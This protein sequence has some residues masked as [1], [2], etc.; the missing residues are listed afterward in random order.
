M[1][2][3]ALLWLSSLTLPAQFAWRDAGPGRL[4]LIEK[5]R[6]VMVFNY[7]PQLAPGVA[8]DRRRCCYIHPY[9][10]PSG[11]VLT[12]DFP[13]DHLHHRGIFWAWPQVILDG[14]TLDGWMMKGL[15]VRHERF[16]EKKPTLL[17]VENGWYAGEKK[18][19]TETVVITP[20]PNHS[21]ALAV[22]LE[23]LDKPVTLGGSREAGKGYGGVSVRFAPRENTVIRTSEGAIV[24]DEDLNP[25]LMAELEADYR[26][27]KSRLRI[28]A[29][30]PLPWCL[31]FYG[32]LGPSWPAQAKATLEP[33]K[34]VTLRYRFE[35]FD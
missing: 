5:G 25:H 31:R 32:F 27:N 16:L 20:G 10:S 34:P 9:Y 14:N 7:G 2:Y 24:K 11:V 18:I 23:A 13:K 17:K 35:S 29:T 1:R 6:P 28:T 12:D 22:T 3:A 8:E 4:E 15:E 21:F 19:V 33:H 30:E 26:G